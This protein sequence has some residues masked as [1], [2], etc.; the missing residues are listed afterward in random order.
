MEQ[1][2]YPDVST[3]SSH[4]KKPHKREELSSIID[5]IETAFTIAEEDTHQTVDQLGKFAEDYLASKTPALSP[6]FVH[7]LQLLYMEI[8]HQ[9]LTIHFSSFLSISKIFELPT[10]YQYFQDSRNIERSSRRH[11]E[12]F[13][14]SI[15]KNY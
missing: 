7:S 2:G 6:G 9:I 11:L 1:V 3:L 15:S 14:Y 13:R 8:R 10:T 4:T 12:C 5:T